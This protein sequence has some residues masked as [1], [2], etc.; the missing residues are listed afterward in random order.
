MTKY[1]TSG[2]VNIGMTMA[3]SVPDKKIIIKNVC[4]KYS[5]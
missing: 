5:C 1:I 3:I 4:A 2:M